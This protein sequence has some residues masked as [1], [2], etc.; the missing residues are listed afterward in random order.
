MKIDNEIGCEGQEM[1]ADKRKYFARLSFQIC[2]GRFQD[3]VELVQ[4]QD[5]GLNSFTFFFYGQLE[6]FDCPGL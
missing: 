1:T 5:L 4:Y 6:M 2:P 3:W